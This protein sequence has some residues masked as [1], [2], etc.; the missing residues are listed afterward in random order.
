MDINLLVKVTSRAW[1]LTILALMHEG[2]PGRQAALLA[3]AGAGRTA[4]AQSLTHLIELGLLERNP[5]H[6]HP[7]RPEY[8]LTDAGKEF[9]GVAARIKSLSDQRSGPRLLR[10]VWT[11]PVLAVS[12]QPQYFGEIKSHLGS[13][14]DRALSQSLKQLETQRWLNREIDTASRPARSVYQAA[15]MGAQISQAIRLGAG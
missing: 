1:S 2:I 6:G 12:R 9:A 11:V 10:R 8:R 15:N 5:G 7:L 3:A 13:I 14:T 4:F